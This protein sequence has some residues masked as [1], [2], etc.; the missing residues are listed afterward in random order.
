MTGPFLSSEETKKQMECSGG[1]CRKIVKVCPESRVVIL[2]CGHRKVWPKT[3][4]SSSGEEVMN[5][6]PLVGQI[7][8]CHTSKCCA[9]CNNIET[10]R[11]LTVYK[12]PNA[13]W[14]CIK[15]QSDIRG[16]RS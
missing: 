9:K 10:N 13:E 7:T 16:K 2:V 15:D 11:D 3:Y 4:I 14:A 6:L 8:S 5:S 12:R 1:I